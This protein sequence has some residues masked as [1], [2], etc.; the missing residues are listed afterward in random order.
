MSLAASSI[1]PGE[2]RSIFEN[3]AALLQF[4]RDHN[5]KTLTCTK[6]L[7]EM[8]FSKAEE[9]QLKC[10][11]TVTMLRDRLTKLKKMYKDYAERRD[12][13]NAA[14]QQGILLKCHQFQKYAWEPTAIAPAA[15]EAEKE[16]VPPQGIP[17]SLQHISTTSDQVMHLH[18]IASSCQ[19]FEHIYWD[20]HSQL[21]NFYH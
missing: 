3:G 15:D 19:H 4:M 5:G 9:G 14:A 11:V 12:A 18:C 6:A 20:H 13:I 2:N 7:A 16:N 21:S 17:G 10:T 1:P 8:A